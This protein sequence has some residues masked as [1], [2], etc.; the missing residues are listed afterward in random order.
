M[1]ISIIAAFLAG[2]ITFLSPCVLPLIPAYLGYLAGT[3]VHHR[4]KQDANVRKKILLHSLLF[5]AGFA[6]VFSLLGVLLATILASISWQVQIWLSRIGGLLIILFGLYL[7]GL[8]NLPALKKNYDLKLDWLKPS[9]ASSFLF[10]AAFAVGW[11][12]CVGPV[13]GSILALTLTAPTSAFFLLLAFSLG[14]GVPFLIVGAFTAQASRL[15][16]KAGPWLKHF[17]IVVGILLILFG[18][19]I[20][21]N[22]MGHIADF[23]LLNQLFG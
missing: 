6:M 10:G 5:V 14:F 23:T 1:D 2:F 21:T 18:I 15:I 16:R 13:L 12:P 19:L 9:L 22:N 4:R 7:V 3:T 20:F 8:F 17:E 11:T